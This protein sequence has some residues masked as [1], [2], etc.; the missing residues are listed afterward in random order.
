MIK[1]SK[2][3]ITRAILDLDTSHLELRR[4]DGSS[5]SGNVFWLAN[6]RRCG[7][8]ASKSAMCAAN[9][10]IETFGRSVSCWEHFGGTAASRKLITTVSAR[11]LCID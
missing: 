8:N 1:L 9:M 5:F 4:A 2:N 3:P 7:A 6:D 10:V 11:P